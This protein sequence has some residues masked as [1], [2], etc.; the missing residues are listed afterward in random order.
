MFILILV[1]LRWEVERERG[2]KRERKRGGKRE[3]E[4]GGKKERERGGS[5]VWAVRDVAIMTAKLAKG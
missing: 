1:L 2:G 4:R 5:K 3:R